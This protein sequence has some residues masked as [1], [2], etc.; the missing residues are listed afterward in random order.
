M[1]LKDPKSF[2]IIGTRVRGVDNHAIVTGKP[3]YGIDIT[4]PG[5]LYAVY[6]KC[7]V[8]GG[9][10][11][12]A[13]LDVIKREPGVRHAFVVE[14]VGTE[15]DGPPRRRGHRRRQLVARPLGAQEAAGGVERGADARR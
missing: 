14:G 9:T 7:P 8:F 6:E 1:T 11:K 4:L 12:S 15:L 3:L 5:M 10:V 13:N 2:R